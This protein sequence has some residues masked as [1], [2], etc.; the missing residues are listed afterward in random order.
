M[1]K[2]IEISYNGA[3]TTGDWN[4]ETLGEYPTIN[5][6]MLAAGPGLEWQT[7]KG[8]PG[9]VASVSCSC[10]DCLGEEYTD[11]PCQAPYWVIEPVQGD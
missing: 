10:Q 5:A 3:R 6:A 4:Y 1:Y 8:R 11:Y 9:L 7:R 2:L